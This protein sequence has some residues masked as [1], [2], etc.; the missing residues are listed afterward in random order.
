MADAWNASREA[1]ID[2]GALLI[3]AKAVLPHGDSRAMVDAELPFGHVEPEYR[4]IYFNEILAQLDPQKVVADLEALAGGH[5]PVLL[6]FERPPFTPTNWC[7]RRMVAEWLADKIGL[8]V[9]ELE[10][11]GGAAPPAPGE[12]PTLI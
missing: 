3:E 4:N 8:D 2:A 12:N 10:R 9:P 1:L 7:H 11:G 5:E 6:C